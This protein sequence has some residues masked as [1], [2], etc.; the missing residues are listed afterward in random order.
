MTHEGSFKYY[1]DIQG[2][3]GFKLFLYYLTMGEGSILG[4]FKDLLTAFK[5]RTNDKKF[6]VLRKQNARSRVSAYK[7]G[8]V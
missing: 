4:N 6:N 3:R 7:G 1:V 2:G 8:R 5:L